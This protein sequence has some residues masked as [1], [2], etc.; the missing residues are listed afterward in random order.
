MPTGRQ[1]QAKPIG[2]EEW[3]EIISNFPVKVK[4][5]FISGGEPT[6]IKWLPELCNWLLDKG[7]HVTIFSNLWS[8]NLLNCLNKSYRLQIWATFHQEQDTAKR[9]DSVYQYLK[10]GGYNIRVGELGHKSQILPY[11]EMQRF[12]TNEEL[13]EPAFRY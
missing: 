11:S 10:A 9:F 3:K 7:Y 4:E 6:L 2:L 13:K 1:P 8:V 12:T 5:I